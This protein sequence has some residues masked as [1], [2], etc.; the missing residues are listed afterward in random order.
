MS[1][2]FTSCVG[3]SGGERPLT[4]SAIVAQAV[5]SHILRIDGYSRTK[6]LGNGTCIDSDT[7]SA[8]GHRWRLQYYPDGF[9][10]RYP[11]WI[12]LFLRLEHTTSCFE[13]EVEAKF[14]ISLL[15]QEGNPVPS[16][17]RNMES[18]TFSHKQGGNAV[19]GCGGL[20]RHFDLERS[21]YLKDDV[22]SLRC[23]VAVLVSKI[24]TRAI[25][26]SAVCRG[27]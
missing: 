14:K 25:P 24:V 12:S 6:A 11:G 18:R 3:G 8:G 27:V 13:G 15:D 2:P 9:D 19:F 21:E 4:A 10:N 5:G 23:D 7:F 26:V 16:Y 1:N 20:I 22:F 17:T